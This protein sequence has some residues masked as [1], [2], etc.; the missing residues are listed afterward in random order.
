HPCF[1]CHGG[2][3]TLPVAAT[4]NPRA[5]EPMKYLLAIVL[6]IVSSSSFAAGG[7]AGT[8]L[9]WTYQYVIATSDDELSVQQLVFDL[10]RE[11][12]EMCDQAMLD[13]LAEFLAN[14]NVR[15]PG[16]ERGLK[17]VFGILEMGEAARYRS[18]VDQVGKKTRLS[19][20]KSLASS[21]V[22]HHGQNVPQ[23]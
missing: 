11:H 23:Y 20:I 1:P 9:Y 18:V 10:P 19:S 14:A 5:R 6:F 4:N 2:A 21:F 3:G 12:P 15:D 16:Y 7:A 13:L 8:P 17:E 22:K